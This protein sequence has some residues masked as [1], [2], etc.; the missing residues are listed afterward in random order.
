[1]KSIKFLLC[2]TILVASD[3]ALADAYKCMKSGR[4]IYQA[5]PCEVDSEKGKLDIKFETPEEKAQ[6]Q[7]KLDALKA[8][9]AAGKEAEDQVAK[10]ATT[11][12]AQTQPI[13]AQP[14]ST[15][16]QNRYIYG[17]PRNNPPDPNSPQGPVNIIYPWGNPKYVPPAEQ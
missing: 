13:P 3:C 8:E 11:P 10:T 12:S 4:P 17:N 15:Q 2:I 1:M 14:Q 16:P 6:A 9:Y 5:T 7:E